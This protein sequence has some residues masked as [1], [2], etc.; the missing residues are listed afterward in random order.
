MVGTTL[1]PS[2]ANL[3]AEESFAMDSLFRWV[4]AACGAIVVV[5]G[6]CY[7]WCRRVLLVLLSLFTRACVHELSFATCSH[8]ASVALV[9]RIRHAHRRDV[10]PSLGGA[11]RRRPCL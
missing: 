10:Q 3:V 6:W 8:L 1:W 9:S 2:G 5:V 7:R 4:V 11:S